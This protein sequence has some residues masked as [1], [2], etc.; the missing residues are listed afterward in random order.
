M[1]K[2]LLGF[3]ALLCF[4]IAK[5][6]TT[7]VTGKV[8]D[9]KGAAIAGASV[10]EKG[11]KNGTAA[12]NDGTFSLSVK[13]KAILVI[14][15][16]GFDSKEVKATDNLAITL[17]PD[18]K[19]LSEVV[20]TGVG[21]ATS[22]K[23]LGISVESITGDKLPSIPTASLDQAIIGKIPGA[24]ISSVSGNPGD[25]VNI[26]LRGINTVQGGT[27]PLVLLDGIE[28]PFENLTTIDL[29]QV[30]R[31]EV[32]QGAASATLYGAQG[33]NGVIQIFSKKGSK[34]RLSINVSSSYGQNSYIN[35]GNFGKASLHPYLTDANGTIVNAG[36]NSGLGYEAGDPVAIDPIT[37]I[38]PGSNSISYR[39]G[40]NIPGLSTATPGA[41]ENYTRYGI[42]DP[43]NKN[44]QPYKNGLQ[45]HD[46]FAEVFE[47]APSINN[48]I[49][50]NGGGEKVD[51]NFALS[52]SQ[53]ASALLKDNGTL[54]RTNMSLNL[55]VQ[56]T[57]NL[58]IRSITNLVYTKNDMHPGL[59]APGGAYYGLGTSNANV[60]AVYGFL[61]TSPFFSLMDTILGGHYSVY[62][63]ASFA[64]VNAGN[65][66]F[67]L[68]YT[69]GDSKR[70]DIMQNFEATYKLNKYI[71]FNARYGLTYKTENDVWTWY[72]QSQNANVED[73]ASWVSWYA[74]DEFGEIDNWQYSNKKQNL[75]ASMIGKVDFD[76]DLN[77]HIPLQSTTQVSYDYRRNDYKE[78]DTWGQTLALDP[79]FTLN[80][81]QS[82]HV[83][84][85]YVEPFV[86]Y[87][88]LVDQKFDFGNYGGLTGGFRTDY[89][90][91][92]GAGSK[93][94]TFPHFNAYINIPAFDF[95]S[96]ISKVIPNFKL[97]AAYGKAGIQPGPFDRYPVLNLQPTGDENTYTNQTAS[98][99]PNLDVEV[100]SEKEIGTD[101]TFNLFDGNWLR[102]VNASFTYWK[103]HTDNAIFNQNVPPST[104]ATQLLTNAIALSSKGW[105]LGVNIPVMSSKNLT[106]DF[107]AN[108]GHQ[109]SLIESV[110]G[111]DIPLT[112]GAGSTGL[113]LSAGRKIGEIYG[114]KALTSVSQLR[115][116]KTP[117]IA[118]ADQ[119][120]YEIVNGR[121]VN[122]TTKA[123]FF[124]D[125][126]ESLGD[127][128]PTL[129][130]SFI[131][132]FTWKG[133]L[134]FG[135]QF[136]W[137]KGSHL[138]NQTNEWMY[139]DAISSDFT[140]PVT[141]NG[142]TGAW[143]AYY[144]SA[145]YALGNTP[146]G[147]GNNVTKDF[148]YED[149]SFVR[150]RNVSLGVDFSRF[151]KRDWLKKCQLVFSGRNLLT[152]TNYNGM[153]PEI[154]SGAS[155]S[156][157][158]RGIDH[159]TIPNMKSY[160]VT[161]NLGF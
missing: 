117:F 18:T 125:E 73:Q 67:R 103:R 133:F 83:S 33:A 12:A 76:K 116:D 71:N 108:F 121:V 100:S 126:A 86:T 158:D 145:Y 68:E 61:N 160:Q 4:V 26:V 131:N 64:S 84:V 29:T 78:L 104:G 7:T 74:P 94:F 119:G 122:K 63:R 157:F 1:R 82:Q 9:E 97:R 13:P 135:F 81:T 52:N 159:S 58:H 59:G 49:S 111:G 14:T 19:A 87:G 138:Y 143:T 90:S 66:F 65:P 140:R 20:V 130:S 41:T 16:L 120:N 139:R 89:S 113:V 38:V 36:S 142:E 69:A 85:D 107:T 161:L 91:A 99:N 147:V 30:E 57:K 155:N 112:S 27:R 42:L 150:L 51:F 62:Q 6:Q 93:P 118:E 40:S 137:V 128:N 44:D 129:T 156:A 109:E 110:A 46:H 75:F 50:L 47:S 24:Q 88:Y 115:A 5:A 31:V 134:S 54:N 48:T 55:G 45:Y 92:F 28:I 32:V 106:W 22:K 17:N 146:K 154:S 148:F 153:D 3:A 56:V 25:K 34:G 96:S 144:A 35:A 21:T 102:S 98:K 10:I 43:R 37:G 101:L 77:I 39:Y 136:D 127:P 8:T 72:N 141:I 2:F 114:Y 132:S 149:A 15:A 53:T 124:S 60:G 123:I 70:Y 151:A 23:K 11:T 95:W 105:Q 80:S 79:P 152:F